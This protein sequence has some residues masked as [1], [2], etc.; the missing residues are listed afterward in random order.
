MMLERVL[1][2]VMVVAVEEVLEPA[3]YQFLSRPRDCEHVPQTL[4]VLQSYLTRGHARIS[5]VPA[6][7]FLSGLVYVSG[8]DF[9]MRNMLFSHDIR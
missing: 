8:C 3:R 9:H 5:E 1:V 6:L 4:A 2:R 7:R